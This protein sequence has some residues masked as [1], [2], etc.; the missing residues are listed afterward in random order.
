MATTA[1]IAK[2]EKKRRNSSFGCATGASVAGGRA[3]FSQVFACAV[4][5]FASLRW[6]AK[7]PA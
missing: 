7:F 2:E 6:P 1:K 5:A 4:S 3:D